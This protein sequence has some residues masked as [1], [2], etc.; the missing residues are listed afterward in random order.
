MLAG[1]APRVTELAQKHASVYIQYLIMLL[2][3]SKINNLIHYLKNVIL[4]NTLL[5][6]LF[7]MP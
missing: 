7:I 2:G 1:I 3:L 4:G 5:K 6:L